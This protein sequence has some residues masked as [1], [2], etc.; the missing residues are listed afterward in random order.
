MAAVVGH[1]FHLPTV[2]LA[3]G[4][5]HGAVLDE[6]EE[7]E[8][9][10]IIV[11]TPGTSGNY[12]FAHA[13]IRET[14]YEELP[15]IRRARLHLRVAEAIEALYGLHPA[16]H[17]AELAAHYRLAIA[18]TPAG[19]AAAYARQAGDA[20]AAVFAWEEAISQ[21][22]MALD[23]AGPDDWPARCELLLAIGEAQNN[24]GEREKAKETLLKAAE[25]ARRLHLAG[26]GLAPKGVRYLAR[27]AL[28]Y[29]GPGVVLGALV[30]RQVSL[31][32]EALAA[33]RRLE[34]CAD[35]ASASAGHSSEPAWRGLSARLLA[36]LALALFWTPRRQ[37]SFSL[38]REAIAVARQTADPKALIAALHT[39]RYVLWSA[40]HLDERSGYAD[41]IVELAEAAGEAE[42][43]LQ[44]LRWRIVDHLEL[45]DIAAVDAAIERYQQLAGELRHPYY[46]WYASL[47]RATRAFAMGQY[48]EGEHLAREALAFGYRAGDSDAEMFFTMQI[49]P[50]RTQQGRAAELKATLRDLTERYPAMLAYRSRLTVLYAE[51]GQDAE[52]RQ[53]FDDIARGT[54][55]PI[56]GEFAAVP[57]DG[58]WLVTMA[59]FARACVLL[60]DRVR[61]ATLYELLRPFAGRNVVTGAAIASL[62]PTS[63]WLGG[64]A[65]LLG[66]AEEAVAYF[67]AALEMATRMEATPQLALTQYAF[68]VLLL[69]A[70]A[71]SSLAGARGV[72]LLECSLATAQALGMAPLEAQIRSALAGSE[73]AR[74]AG[75]T[76][77]PDGLS[78][79]KAEVL[80]LVAAGRSNREIAETLVLSV[81]TVQNHIANIYRKADIHNRAEAATYALRHGLSESNPVQP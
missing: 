48:A 40:E 47:F 52:A 18:V 70:E 71:R 9:T 33:T 25:A 35:D 45:G 30:Q 16:A 24:V 58:N 22:N 41:E 34:P 23:L 1:E 56:A 78:A 28:G 14:L 31:L 42:L 67:E 6:L 12:R 50:A 81:V 2:A 46:Q 11:Q 55:D 32:E 10:G 76:Q 7:A 19:K 17:V 69:T 26:A 59:N 54:A 75:A 73:P 72:D 77:F 74:Q 13:L 63:Y 5:E 61:A 39:R 3:G 15:T 36:R 68:A 43:T 44:G 62:G 21:W 57:R 4:M 80:R 8:S 37:Q 49:L 79:R 27:A 20:A 65:A 53:A 29:G 64:L 38:S 60:G 51:L 66:Q